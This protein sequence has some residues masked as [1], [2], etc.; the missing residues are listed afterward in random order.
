MGGRAL[1][2]EQSSLGEGDRARTDRRDPG[3]VGIRG[4]QRA[5][6]FIGRT[7]A[8]VVA[9]RN[10]DRIRTVDL[11]DAVVGGDAHWPRADD[12]FGT[13]HQ[14]AISRLTGGQHHPAEHLDR[15]GQVERDDIG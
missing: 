11:G 15:G 1:S 12:G 3:A 9:A 14:H 13:A 10:D 7:N 4:L 2:V 8:D 5:Q 6:H